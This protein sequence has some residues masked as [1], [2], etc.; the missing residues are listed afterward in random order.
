MITLPRFVR[1]TT[2]QSRNALTYF[3]LRFRILEFGTQ[4]RALLPSPPSDKEKYLY[5]HRRVRLMLVGSVISFTCMTLSLITFIYHH[6]ILLILTLFL[7][8]NILYFAV[9]MLV[10]FGTADFNL[11]DHKLKVARWH[12]DIYPSVDIFLPTAG[13]D[14]AVIENTWKGVQALAASYIGSV[15][16]YALDDGASP[17]VEAMAQRF[18][19]TYR[20]RPNRG[21]FKKAGNL[22]YGFSISKSRYIVIFDADFTPRRD[23]LDETLPYFS[24]HTIG[25]IQTP[26][27][28]SVT[29]HQNWLERGAGAVQ[30]LFYRFSQV[31][32]QSNDASICVGSNAV[33]R[34]EALK[35]TGGTALIEH[36]EDVHTGF[37]LRMNKWD[38]RY[39]P[40]IVAKGLCPATMQSFF[41]Q[42][43]RWCM[44]SMSLMVS[45][46]FWSMDLGLRTRLSYVSGFLYYI[47]TALMVC[48]TPLLPLILLIWLPREINLVNYGLIFPAFIFS[49]VI[50]PLWHRSIYGVEA[51]A[52][53]SVYGWAHLFAVVDHIR[54]RPM[55]W[56][57]TGG[58]TKKDTRYATFRTLQV[59]FNLVP[60]VVWTALGAKYLIVTGNLSFLPITIS[61]AY[62]LLI[63]TKVAASYDKAVR[64]VAPPA[65]SEIAEDRPAEMARLVISN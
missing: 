52:T 10:N 42:Q 61:G 25:I 2:A 64:S 48:Y 54:G 18:G 62:Y 43:Y 6:P 39:V 40:I 36:S 23:F 15:K 20:V 13:E 49:Q 58:K 16:V 53:R 44:G 63:T 29:A 57:P 56:Q 38:V 65:K 59:L 3:F 22:R 11:K 1:R 30:E 27:Y 9:S 37:N 26:Q 31:S 35:S 51:W 60:A 14:I 19:F 21:Y 24:D 28:F 8:L 46:K 32:R 55:G 41:K 5:A 33:Y 17:Q 47:H 7:A 34:R 45:R 12:P 4:D 50:F